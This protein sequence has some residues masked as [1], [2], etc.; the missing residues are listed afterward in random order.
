MHQFPKGWLSDNHQPWIFPQNLVGGLPQEN[1]IVQPHRGTGHGILLPLLKIASRDPGAVVVLLPAN[2]H[3]RDEEI[4]A[5]SLR[6]AAVLA[7]R[8]P[9]CIYR[10]AVHSNRATCHLRDCE[11]AFTIG[12]AGASKK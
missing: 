9:A 1:V 10:A 12:A 5:A 3:L 6:H 4:M 7:V 2:H 8:N 11:N